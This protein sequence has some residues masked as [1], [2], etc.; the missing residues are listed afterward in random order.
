MSRFTPGCYGATSVY[1]S[2]NQVCIECSLRPQCA[3]LSEARRIRIKDELLGDLKPK[4]KVKSIPVYSPKPLDESIDSLPKKP[5]EIAVRLNKAGLLEQI[6]KDLDSNVNTFDSRAPKFLRVVMMHLL[7]S[8][9]DRA[10][11]KQSFVRELGWGDG[12]AA[13]HVA[14]SVALVKGLN[15]AQEINGRFVRGT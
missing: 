8:G 11:L 7:S 3:D 2:K 5:R 9:F 13:S 10:S 6:H 12:T 1:R 4:P 15:W 14:I